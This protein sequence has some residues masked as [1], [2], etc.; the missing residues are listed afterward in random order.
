MLD[1]FSLAAV[2]VGLALV[3]SIL[4]SR[5]RVSNA[6][7]DIIIGVFAAA[8]INHFVGPEALGPKVPWITFLA[9]TAAVVLTFLAG[10]ELD[11][12]SLRKSW[13][14][15]LVVGV[16]SGDGLGYGN[17]PGGFIRP[18]QRKDRGLHRCLRRNLIP[19]SKNDLLVFQAVQP[20]PPLPQTPENT[21]AR[22][23]DPVLLYPGRFL[24]F[25]TC[26]DCGA[27]G[28]FRTVQR[29]SIDKDIRSASG[30]QALPPPQQGALVLYA[31]HV[32][33]PDLWFDLSDVRAHTRHY[34]TGSV[35][36]PRRSGD[37]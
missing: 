33:R 19:A 23:S 10:A 18:A 34:F 22:V 36:T 5:L 15:A 6:L 9:G 29:Q 17:R 1:V 20:G 12:H 13:K 8:L 32:H 24:R 2:W 11:P 16:V 14:E 30:R 31:P 4:A 25:N 7:V 27:Y 21:D 37:R 26:S 28:L 35:L 3:S